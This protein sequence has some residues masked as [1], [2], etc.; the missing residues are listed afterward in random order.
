MNTTPRTIAPVAVPHVLRKPVSLHVA[1]LRLW[2]AAC[3]HA[4]RRDRFVPYC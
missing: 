4:E 1:L 2:R 3:R